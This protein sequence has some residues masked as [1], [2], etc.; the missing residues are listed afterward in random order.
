MVAIVSG[1]SL[2][3]SLTSLATGQD[4]MTGSAAAGRQGQHIF[5]NTSNGNLVLQKKDDYLVSNGLDLSSLRT[6][7]SQGSA[8]G[9][10]NNDNWRLGC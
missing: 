2:G 7:N 5:V 8:D 9:D 4:T 10:G 6:Y 1:S 3:L